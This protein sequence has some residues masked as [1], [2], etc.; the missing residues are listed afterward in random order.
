M[1]IH[2][3]PAGRAFPPATQFIAFLFLGIGGL[4]VFTEP[5]FGTSIALI[6]LI[7][8]LAKTGDQVDVSLRKTRVYHSFFGLTFGK[9]KSIEGYVNIAVLRKNLSR[10]MYSRSGQ[11]TTIGQTVFTATLLDKDHRKKLPVAYFS[12]ASKAAEEVEKLAESLGIRYVKFAPK[13]SS[14]R[15]R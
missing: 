1:S 3:Y 2:T 8:L 11:S 4:L 15:R 10:T 7:L 13:R 9:W 5:I 12:S 6:G 14:K